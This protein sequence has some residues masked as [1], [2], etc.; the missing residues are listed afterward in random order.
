MSITICLGFINPE[1]PGSVLSTTIPGG[2][3][4]KENGNEVTELVSQKRSA[5]IAQNDSVKTYW[6]DYQ[7]NE[8]NG[9][10]VEFKGRYIETILGCLADE[11]NQLKIGEVSRFE[12]VV[13]PLVDSSHVLVLSYL[14]SDHDTIRI[15]FQTERVGQE[16][17]ATTDAAVGYPISLDEFCNEAAK[18]IREYIEYARRSGFEPDEWESLEELDK[19]AD[20]LE[21]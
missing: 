13:I 2:I 12:Q 4:I 9:G 7:G 16:D 19:K 17:E 8:V 21:D 18:S 3:K 11:L 6:Y 20:E 15:A 1:S 10:E 14:N 5:D